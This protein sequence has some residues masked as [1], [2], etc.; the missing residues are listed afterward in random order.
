MEIIYLTTFSGVLHLW[1]CFT[2]DV[3]DLQSPTQGHQSP[4]GR[5][6]T[7]T[8][9]L[10]LSMYL[11]PAGLKMF[12]CPWGAKMFCLLLFFVYMFVLMQ[13][14]Y[15]YSEYN[16]VHFKILPQSG[17]MRLKISLLKEP[18]HILLILIAFIMIILLEYC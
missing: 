16:Q 10:P 14:L 8:N 4:L 5:I 17:N 18:K 7:L 3:E 6:S 13:I 1:D 9:V 11:I 2:Q 12:Q 15:F